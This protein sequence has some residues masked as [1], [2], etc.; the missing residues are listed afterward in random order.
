MFLFSSPLT[1]MASVEN[2]NTD[3]Q[4]VGLPVFTSECIDEKSGKVVAFDVKTGTFLESAATL[5]ALRTVMTGERQPWSAYAVP[6]AD[7]IVTANLAG[8]DKN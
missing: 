7:D 1:P 6:T 2:G 3:I 5:D 4:S 8:E